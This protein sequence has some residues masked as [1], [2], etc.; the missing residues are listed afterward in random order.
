[1]IPLYQHSWGLIELEIERDLLAVGKFGLRRARGTFP[2]GSSFD[3]PDGDPLPVPLEIGSEVR[4][5]VVNLAVPWR[6]SSVT[7]ATGG[8]GAAGTTTHANADR[9]SHSVLWRLQ[10][11]E[12]FGTAVQQSPLRLHGAPSAEF[13]QIPL[14]HIIESRPDKQVVLDDRFIPT[15][16]ICAAAPRLAAF[17]VELQALMHGRAESLAAR[18]AAS[19][20]DGAAELTDFLMLQ[21]LNRYEP[22]V[23]QLAVTA[24]CHPE[25]LHRLALEIAGDLA[26]FTT[27]SR[28]P[29]QFPAY[30]H[31]ALRPSFEPV[32]QA[33][34]A[35]LSVV[36]E[37]SAV[38]I[39]LASPPSASIPRSTDRCLT[40][41]IVGGPDIAKLPSRSFTFGIDGGRIGRSPDCAWVLANPHVSRHHATIR[42][43]GGTY[44]IES[45][46][47]N[48]VAV[49]SRHAMLPQLERRP[50]HGGD[51]LFIDEYEITVTHGSRAPEAA[52]P[53]FGAVAELVPSDDPFVDPAPMRWSPVLA[54]SF[55]P[56]T[57]EPAAPVVEENL[58]FTVYRPKQLIPLCW[59][60]LLAFAHLSE[61]PADADP[62]QPDPIE[63]VASQAEAF[64]NDRIHDYRPILKP[65]GQTVSRESELTF[66]PMVDGLE[67]EPPQHSFVW[68]G[69]VHREVFLV[70]AAAALVGRTQRGRLAVFLGSLVIAEV[71]LSIPIAAQTRGNEAGNVVPLETARRYRK[72]FASYS[73]KD[74]SI[75]EECERYARVLGDEYMRDVVSLR[76][77]EVWSTRLQALITSAD[78]FQLFWSWNSM[79]S[80][81]VRSEWEHALRLGRPEFIRPVY[82][83]D[84]LP[85]RPERNLPPQSLQTVHF[86]RL[87]T[88]PMH[89]HPRPAAPR[90]APKMGSLIGG[91][92]NLGPAPDAAPP[93]AGSVINNRFVLEEEIGRGE[94][95]IVFK[96]RDLRK[97][98]VRERNP[99][100]AVKVFNAQSKHHREFLTALLHVGRQ[101]LSLAH[102]NIVTV[103]E[104]DLNRDNVFGVMELLEG[105]A[106]GRLIERV[107][108]SGLKT[109]EALRISRDICRAMAY[110]HERG[111]V[112]SDFKP[113]S[114]FLTQDGV[115]KV[116]DFGIARVAQR[117][118]QVLGSTTLIENSALRELTSTY[119]SCEMI[120]GL[121][122]DVRDDVY[123]IACITYELLTGNHPFDGISAVQARDAKLVAKRPHGLSRAQWRTL[124]KGLA[125]QRDERP[126]DASAFA[127]GLE[128][129]WLWHLGG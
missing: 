46:G 127:K 88:R 102:P 19:R 125:F 104:F 8:Q 39:P 17:L 96:A 43:I 68:N 23:R 95:G 74:E 72:I 106:L 66:L 82:W 45:T 1:V 55:R 110:A 16:M 101:A 80:S 35:S 53:S 112:H 129:A 47:E 126:I 61:R 9:A 98:E 79:D 93:A 32:I 97:E 6:K 67:F 77:G 30:R 52:R 48:G 121:E 60:Q 85:C 7:H 99:Y 65:A 117:R 14:A 40:L 120:E 119:T 124:Q 12:E 81:F 58:Q 24:A 44:Y 50:L 75:V 22:L 42:W 27:I 49:N 91:N 34:R 37:Q 90:P 21:S 118:K 4:N 69:S 73:R 25:D 109:R 51:R 36:L 100:V 103:Y 59:E 111:V 56:A 11:A 13:A 107:R 116:F 70:R 123:A 89:G 63:E 54:E 92:P 122:P 83:E 57:P 87:P 5:Q 64:L 33:L 2:D 84:P 71:P 20:R 128:S 18:A 15:V 76:A 62:T 94:T 113:A 3:I 115:V 28:R 29:P 31:D 114:A 38:R 26:T 78:V 105:E 86:Q 10:S 108:G 41:E